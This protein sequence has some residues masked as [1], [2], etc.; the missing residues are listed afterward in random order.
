MAQR[1][2]RG[3]AARFMLLAAIPVCRSPEKRAPEIASPPRRT[4]VSMKLLDL[5]FWSVLTTVKST[6]RAGTVMP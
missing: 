4:T 2:I 5:Y 3:K 6:S 1:A